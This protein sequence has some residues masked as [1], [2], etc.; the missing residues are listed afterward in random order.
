MKLTFILFAFIINF[1][2]TNFIKAEEIIDSS[3]NQIENTTKVESSNNEI[4]D[5]KKTHIVQVGDTITSISNLYSIKKDFIIKLNNLKD[6][7][8]IYVG[9]NLKI[10][11][12]SQENKPNKDINNSYHLV[13]KGESLTEISTKYGLNFKELIK[14]NNLKNPDSLE[15]GSKLFLSEKN[16]NNQ[17]V[18]TSLKEEKINQFISKESKKY[19]PLKTQQTELEEGSGRKFLNALNQNNKKVIISISCATKDLDVRIPGKR[20]R[21]WIPAKEEFEKNLINDF[22]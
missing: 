20:W 19:G 2:N 12:S 18:N 3:N 5:F 1:F 16:I 14:I 10:Y 8:Y 21:G 22:C 17:E 7:N 15:V 11:D 13:Q 9:Q 4:S 6:E